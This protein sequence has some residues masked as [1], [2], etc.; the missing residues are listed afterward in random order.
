MSLEL[1]SIPDAVDTETD[2]GLRMNESAFRAFYEHTSAPLLRFL[3]CITRRPDLAEDILQETYCRLLTA[4]LPNMDDRQIRNYLFRIASN[5]VRDR[6]RRTR[7]HLPPENAVEIP[8]PASHLERKL[9]V[10]QAFDRLKP[11][12]RQLLWLAYVEGSSHQE[13]AEST[14][15]RSASIRLLLFRARRKMAGLITK[16]TARDPEMSP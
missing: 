3:V 5:L 13:I 11:R 14:G 12:E 1:T 4:R 6:W 16:K 10:R 15:L 8:A 7:D 9:G 2:G